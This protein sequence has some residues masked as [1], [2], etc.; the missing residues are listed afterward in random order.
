MS[1]ATIYSREA[2]EDLSDHKDNISQDLKDN[3]SQDLKE[4][5]SLGTREIYSKDFKQTLT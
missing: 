5:N 4:N 2:E 1:L 3:N